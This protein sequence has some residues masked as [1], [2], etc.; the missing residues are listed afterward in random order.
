VEPSHRPQAGRPAVD[1][2]GVGGGAGRGDL[3]LKVC[4]C[5]SVFTQLAAE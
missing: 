4:Q 5:R 2:P 3:E 1:E